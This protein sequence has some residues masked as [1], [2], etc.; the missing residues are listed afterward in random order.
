MP[1]MRVLASVIHYEDSGTGTAFVFLHGDSGSSHLWRNVLPRIGPG[2]LLAP[3]PFGMG[4]SGVRYPR[5]K[6]EEQGGRSA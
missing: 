1:E 4:R 6:Q 5:S 3:D 2:R